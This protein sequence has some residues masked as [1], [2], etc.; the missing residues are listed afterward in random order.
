M[1]ADVPDAADGLARG[2]RRGRRRATAVEALAAELDA[3]ARELPARSSRA[4]STSSATSPTAA[5]QVQ[6]ADVRRALRRATSSGG[7]RR[8][9][10]ERHGAAADLR[11]RRQR[12]TRTSGASPSASTSARR[13]RSSPRCA[14]ASPSACPTRTGAVILPSAVRY[15]VDGAAARV[16]SAPRRSPTRRSTRATPSSRSS[17]SWA[18]ASPTWRSRGRLPYDFVDAPGM[19]QLRTAAGVKSPVEVSAEILATL[20]QRAE[21]S[22]DDELFGAVITVPAYFDDAQRQA[23]K[24]AAQLAGLNVLRLINEPTAAADR[25]RPRQRR[26]GPVRGLR[27]RRRHLRHLAA[28]PDAGRVRG[29]RHRRRFGARRRRLRSPARRLGARRRP[30]SRP[31]TPQDKRAVLVAARAAKEKLSAAPITRRSPARS[32][33]A[34]CRLRVERERVRDADA[35][36]SSTAR[37][38]RCARC[39]ATP[40]SSA[41]RGQGRRAGRRLDPHAAGAGGGGRVL[42]PDAADQPQP[43]RGGRAR[44][45]DP[46]RTRSPATPAP[47]TCCCST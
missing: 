6:G 17:A 37:S 24:D 41:R 45:G 22:F 26:R 23:T 11:T 32:R 7:S 34:N 40:R 2:A 46:G 13:T 29:G 31:S 36:I 9:D 43:R 30:A 38:P 47:A 25:L 18:A 21:D 16:R 1:P 39:C 8:W 20:R 3:D 27:P 15:F 12:P 10:N 28:A 44:R 19:V 4:R 35:P 33:A 42:R 14:T 5:R